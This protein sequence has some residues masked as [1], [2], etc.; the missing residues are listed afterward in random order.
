M[1]ICGQC[2]A[3]L[4]D[5]ISAPLSLYN[6]SKPRPALARLLARWASNLLSP[7]LRL[8]KSN[9]CYTFWSIINYPQMIFN[10]FIV[11]RNHIVIHKQIRKGFVWFHLSNNAAIEQ[12]FWCSVS[13]IIYFF[14]CTPFANFIL[15]M[16]QISSWKVSACLYLIKIRKFWAIIFCHSYIFTEA[17]YLTN[18]RYC[19]N[20]DVCETCS[21]LFSL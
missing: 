20:E 7:E 11:R 21:S 12:N 15:W 17:D 3:R 6:F 1:Y 5:H 4:T 2:G 9:F 18:I 10:I 13:Q 16:I 19:T 14:H 8:S